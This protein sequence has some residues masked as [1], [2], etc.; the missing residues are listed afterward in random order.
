MA[1]TATLTGTFTLPNDA[2]PDSAVLSVTLSAMDTDQNTRHVLPDDGSFTVA[3]VSGAIPAGQEIWKNTAGL[4]GT[5]YRATL[6]WTASDG[7]LLSRYLGS[8]QVGDDASYDMAD[9]LDQ[10]P[11]ATLP[12]G[13]YSTLTQGDY[14]AAIDARDEAVAAAGQAAA[15]RVQTGLDRTATALSAEQAALYDGPRRITVQQLLLDTTLTYTGGSPSTVAPGDS[16]R[17]DFGSFAYRVAAPGAIDHHVITAG[18]VKLYVVQSA[19]GWAVKAF[20]AKG[21]GIADD[22]GPIRGAIAAAKANGGG[23]IVFSAGSYKCLSE[24]LIDSPSI[25]FAGNGRRKVYP[26]LFVPSANTLATIVPVHSGAA[27]LRFFNATINTA[28]TFSAQDIN[29]ATLETGVMPTCCFGFDGS[30]NF[31]RDYTF[32]R[33]GIHGFTSAFDTYNTGGDTAFGLIKI[34][35]CAI[36]RNGHIAR[37][38]TGQWNGF[39]FENNEAGQNLTGGIAIKAQAASIRKNAMEGQPNAIKVAGNY[40]AVTVA[41]NYFELNSGDYCVRLLETLGARVE[42]NFWQNITA[43]EPLSLVYDVSTVVNDRITP[44]CLGSFD[45]RVNNS[46]IN[47]EPLGGSSAAF[48]ADATYVKSMLTGFT[49]MGGY[50]ITPAG[51]HYAFPESAGNIITTSGTGLTSI[52][53][54]GLSIASGNYIAVAV[55]ISYQDE[56]VLPPRFEL[57]VNSTNVDGFI[58]PIFYAF[59]KA[60]QKLKNKTILYFGV[61]KSTALCSSLAV[62]LYPHGINPAAGLV[63]YISLPAIYDL[64]ATLP[65]TA[66]VGPGVAAFVPETHVQRVLAAPVAGTWPIGYKLHARA[67]AAG[68][69][70]GWICTTGGTPGTWKTFGAISA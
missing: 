33:V 29:F 18:G 55:A 25:R 28:S 10:P 27:A 57:S 8:F 4:R 34:T 17:V 30:G 20:G 26:G 59:G 2:A 31:H 63:S 36:N 62:R 32:D 9:L 44:S 50:Q 66:N 1:T 21:D 49:E 15:D 67:P 13:W 45:L 70:E 11:I 37:N 68:G 38:L 64:G 35:N 65:E 52:V 40:R 51:P 14:D 24:I 12:E 19:I 60:N 47:P 23:T 7:R 46:A 58:N 56:P 41:E 61:V 69:F 53:K 42:N 16:V 3:L 43:T 39:V 5:H 48:F 54:T 22:S 6:A